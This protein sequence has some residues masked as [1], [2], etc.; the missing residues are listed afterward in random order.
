MTDVTLPDQTEN[1]T[2]LPPD[3]RPRTTRL[4]PI[5]RPALLLLILIVAGYF[6]FTG[7]NWDEDQLLHPDERYVG[8]LA[9]TI[10]SPKDTSEYFDSGA[11]PLNPFNTDWGR[12]YVYGTLPL[13]LG[14][15]TAEWLDTGCRPMDGAPD[16]DA[17]APAAAP[18]LVGQL[19][20]GDRVKDCVRGTFTSFTNTTL[21]G[22]FGSGLADLLAVLVLFLIG[23]RL[24]GWRT[25]LLAAALSAVAVLQIQQAHFFTVDSTANLFTV[26]TLYFCARMVTRQSPFTSDQSRFSNLTS[27]VALLADGL[28]AGLAA[29]CALASK[30]SVWPLVPLIV[31]SAIV[32]LARDRSRGAA[33]VFYTFAAL[34]LAGVGAFAAFRV[35]QPYAFVGNSPVEFDLTLSQCAS[36]DGDMLHRVCAIAAELPTP[37]RVVFAPSGR[38]IQKL[39]LAQGFVN[40]TIDAPFGHQWANRTPIIF[41]LTNLVFWG[42]GIP[43]GLAACIGLLV[44]LRQLLRGR[45]WWAYLIPVV[46]GGLYFLYQ[47][48]Q[49]TKSMRYLLPVYPVLCLLAAAWL[50]AVWR[51]NR[52][53]KADGRTQNTE[54]RTQTGAVRLGSVFWRLDSV[55]WNLASVVSIPIVVAG[56]LIWAL[57]FTTIYRQPVSRIAASYWAY[58]NIPTAITVEWLTPDGATAGR[59]QLP[60]REWSLT[61]GQVQ[62]LLL[63]P[64]EDAAPVGS[65]TLQLRFNKLRGAGSL[66]V[67]LIDPATNQEVAL[68]RGVISA[69][70]P[71]VS[72]AGITW[73]KPYLAEFEML[74]GDSLTARASVVANEHWDDAV[75]RNLDGKDAYG[76]YYFGL[77]SSTD[78]QIQNYAEEDPGKL[79]QMLDWLDEADYLVMSSNRLY[80]SIPRLPWRFPMATEYYRA[81]FNGE[82]GFELVA[83]FHSFPRIGEFLFNDQ[84]MPQPLRHTPNTRGTTQDIWVPYPTA[85]E[86][87]SVYD[88]PRVL[89]FKKT[90]DYSRAL[91]EQVLGKY[92]PTRTIK[93]TPLDAINT[94]RGML[95]DDTTRAAQQANGTWSELFPRS[96]PLNQ[97][98]LLAVLAW[99]ALIEVLGL[100][101][102]PLILVAVSRQTDDGRRTTDNPKSAIQN[103]KLLDGGYSFAKAL[104][105]LLVA[106]ISWWLGSTKLAMFTAAQIWAVVAAL[107][108][109]GLLVWIRFRSLIAQ[110]LKARAPII[111]ASE[112]VFLLGFA[113]WLM[114]R[115]GNPDLWHP[116]MGGEKPMD[117][118][119]LNGVLRSSYF[120]PIDPWFSGG[121][122]NYYYFG[123]VLIGAPIKALGIDPAIAYNL[124][125]PTLFGLTACGA[126]GLAASFYAFRHPR[127]LSAPLAHGEPTG[128]KVTG[129]K[130]TG[131][132]VSPIHP[133]TLSP[134]HLVTPPIRPRRAILVGV[135]AALFAV[136]VGNWGQP[137]VIFP[138]W[139]KLGG[140]EEGVP[141]LAATVDGFVKWVQ[142]EALPIYPNWPYWNPTRLS[143]AVPIAEF[144][145][146][147]FLYADLH[148]HML[149]MPLVYLAVAFAIAFAAGVRKWLTIGLAAIVVGALWPTNSWDYPIYLVLT[150]GALIVGALHERG[151]DGRHSAGSAL[152]ALARA[153]PALVVFV[154]LT[155][156]FYVPYL[157]NYGSA[158]NQVDRWQAETTPLAVYRTVYG[159]F[160]VPLIVYFVW[161]IW[162]TWRSRPPGARNGVMSL[163]LVAAGATAVLVIGLATQN[164]SIVIVA[165]PMIVLSFLAALMPG[166][167]GPTRV[168]WLMTAGAF[169]LTLFV[170]VFTLRGDIGRM[171]TVFK[172]YIQAWLLLSISAPVVFVWQVERMSATRTPEAPV[173]DNASGQVAAVRPRRMNLTGSV[174]R[175]IFV[176][177]VVASLLV[178]A[179]YP[180][181]AI[182]A[183]V[184]DRY[185]Q[186]APKGLDGMAYMRF[187]ERFEGINGKERTFPLSY[188]YEAIRWM[189]DNV[190]GSPTIIEG[191]TRGDLYRWGNRFSIYTG[192]PAVIGWQWHERQQRAALD[193]RIVYDR[194]NDLVEFYNTPDIGQAL[195]LIRR[196]NAG[197]IILGDLERVYY[198]ESG[199]AKFGEMVERGY[200]ELAYQNPGTTIFRVNPTALSAVW[201]GPPDS[202]AGGAD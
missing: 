58:E 118:A 86:A 24:F 176:A 170:E 89:I 119:Y 90:A 129:D 35:A 30:V 196:Y 8:V 193:D 65:T 174:L 194:D 113:I 109:T 188:D 98:Q 70:N 137:D 121:Y 22:R 160:L 12:D 186:A 197:Y 154:V 126:F 97:S 50:V 57:A 73:D 151:L 147:T 103:P 75:P 127:A 88:H 112:V 149:A 189:Q 166:A 77:S 108:V 117:F 132:N 69:D 17:I 134:S 177:G 42:M 199:F 161:G 16:A 56:T 68:T 187:A 116:Y 18:R 146:F 168:L 173:T 142:G 48:T 184:N 171:N 162:Q 3:H 124:A 150:L 19:L 163:A 202:T 21:I 10:R 64:D 156:A 152:S 15:Y 60:V 37:I 120:P 54:Y 6:R 72:F 181:F 102:F 200:L 128:D 96:S 61:P 198:E 172:F 167:T 101:A 76:A 158:Y 139:Q 66:R 83:D 2:P 55:F 20:F 93:Q 175:P 34:V 78:G 95:F 179:M 85:E 165:A 136:G 33:P 138:A 59:L 111:I 25:G 144:P 45:R 7:V 143:D 63:R 31:L 71:V 135:L 92:D 44:G 38:W 91:A 122:I 43:L 100:I 87:F 11:S 195:M 32:A 14:R 41:P 140:I 107:A 164:V 105:L 190:Q 106:L 9:S 148:A 141:P 26:L 84:E 183:K 115:A 133:V 131:D 114:V 191:T 110:V 79:P 51:G 36:G 74:T 145:Q 67:T 29:G 104:G 180:A 130:V 99:L 80:G 52:A 53:Q 62:T 13:F 47:S 125:V 182:P 27:I 82:L 123:F 159:L 155:R 178:A 153:L 23:R 169:A 40:G 39:S 49:W 4:W 46:W 192:L 1:T 201:N 28:L 157:E 5:I 94:P 185:T 81:L